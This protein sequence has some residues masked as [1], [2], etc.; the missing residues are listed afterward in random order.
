MSHDCAALFQGKKWMD[1][2]W[3][4]K[5]YDHLKF[6]PVDKF[7]QFY[8]EKMRDRCN[9]PWAN[10]RLIEHLEKAI[11]EYERIVPNDDQSEIYWLDIL[12]NDQNSQDMKLDSS[13]W[14]TSFTPMRLITLPSCM[15]ALWI[16][17]GAFRR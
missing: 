4:D 7:L 15:E 2:C 6:H 14:P 17:L 5:A 12:V 13:I 1:G 16:E 10:F 9:Y 11:N 3:A 8:S